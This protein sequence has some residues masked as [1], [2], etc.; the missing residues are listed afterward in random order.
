MHEPRLQ[1]WRGKLQQ[2]LQ[3]FQPPK[4]AGCQGDLYAITPHRSPLDLQLTSYYVDFAFILFC[5]VLDLNGGGSRSGRY[6]GC[7]QRHWLQYDI[8]HRH[9]LRLDLPIRIAQVHQ[10]I[11]MA[12]TLLALLWPRRAVAGTQLVCACGV[13]ARKNYKNIT[14]SSCQESGSRRMFFVVFVSP[15]VGG[16]GPSSRARA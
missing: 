3:V 9:V 16:R 10:T 1:P 12:A 15:L 7:S 11:L 5:F 4:A 14:T 2:G 13:A 8:V 6:V